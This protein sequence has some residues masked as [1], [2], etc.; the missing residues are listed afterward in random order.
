MIFSFDL[1]K[2][3]DS[4]SYNILCNKLKQVKLNPYIMNWLISFLDQRG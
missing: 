3:F 4:V 2:A 1:S